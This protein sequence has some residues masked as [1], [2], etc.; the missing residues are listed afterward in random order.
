MSLESSIGT[1]EFI[2][3]INAMDAFINEKFPS[4]EGEDVWE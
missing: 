4:Q 2:S 3:D 1:D